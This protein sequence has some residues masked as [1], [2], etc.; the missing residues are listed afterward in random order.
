[1]R[2]TAINGA[3]ECISHLYMIGESWPAAKHKGDILAKMV[4]DYHLEST[5][6]AGDVETGVDIEAVST[7]PEQSPAVAPSTSGPP[8]AGQDQ[9]VPLGYVAQQYPAAAGPSNEDYRQ[10]SSAD[11][12]STDLPASAFQPGGSNSWEAYMA[13]NAPL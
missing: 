1:M 7:S 13:P 12:T 5:S 10:P 6:T 3:R 4:E 8:A 2:E 11:I 9:A